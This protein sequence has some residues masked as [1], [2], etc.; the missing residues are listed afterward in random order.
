MK[1]TATK[2]Q[3]ANCLARILNEG[4]IEELKYEIV[5]EILGHNTHEDIEIYVE[6]DFEHIKPNYVESD[7]E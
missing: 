2:S 6:G 3:M 5:V 7:F 4:L 1:L